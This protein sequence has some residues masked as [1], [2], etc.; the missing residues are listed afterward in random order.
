MYVMSCVVIYVMYCM[1]VMYVMYLRSNVSNACEVCNV[2]YRNIMCCNIGGQ[3]IVGHV[4]GPFAKATPT[5]LTR[6]DTCFFKHDRLASATR[7]VSLI[8][9]AWFK[10]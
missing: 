10:K 1:Y 3:G 7:T 2:M 5:F 9:E 6:R 8:V 4:F